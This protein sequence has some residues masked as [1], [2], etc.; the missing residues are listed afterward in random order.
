MKV[1]FKANPV[2]FLRAAVQ[3]ILN[4]DIVVLVYMKPSL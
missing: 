4:Y 3:N 1:N 2:S